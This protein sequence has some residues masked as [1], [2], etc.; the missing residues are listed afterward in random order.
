MGAPTQ[1][2]KCFRAMAGSLGRHAGSRRC[3]FYEAG[4]QAVDA[5]S[6]P[7]A[8]LVAADPDAAHPQLPRRA[9]NWDAG[10]RWLGTLDPTDHLRAPGGRIMTLGLVSSLRASVDACTHTTTQGVA[11]AA[12]L[13]VD[14]SLSHTNLDLTHARY[15]T[16]RLRLLAL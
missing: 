2:R 3:A 9:S 16:L 14:S 8:G 1:C 7:P 6:N 4:H 10:I 11:L 5:G 15:A 12:A 13:R